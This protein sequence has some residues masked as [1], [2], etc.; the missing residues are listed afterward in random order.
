[1]TTASLTMNPS[2]LADSS[3]SPLKCDAFDRGPV[4]R[5]S[6]APNPIRSS[7]PK[8]T[9]NLVIDRSCIGKM[10]SRGRMSLRQSIL[11]GNAKPRISIKFSPKN[12]VTKWAGGL[13]DHYELGEMLGT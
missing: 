2:E 12:F 3:S 13:E 1:M 4:D 10:K 7:S 8:P 5:I 6:S 11:S 9:K